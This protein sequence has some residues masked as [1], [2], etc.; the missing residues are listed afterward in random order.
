MYGIGPLWPRIVPRRGD[1]VE[2][3]THPLPLGGV[4]AIGR[5]SPKFSGAPFG[6][7]PR[8]RIKRTSAH[9]RAPARRLLAEAGE[10]PCDHVA[11]GAA[12]LSGIARRF[13]PR[14]GTWLARRRTQVPIKPPCHLSQIVW[15]IG[16][17]L[18]IVSESKSNTAVCA[19]RD[20]DQLR[21]NQEF[22]QPLLKQP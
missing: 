22:E 11:P 5:T 17:R 7:F 18:G 20:C 4:I 16:W 13:W 8:I 14:P 3:P 6:R 9:S 15:P 1:I 10:G 12:G 21:W 2:T 19:T